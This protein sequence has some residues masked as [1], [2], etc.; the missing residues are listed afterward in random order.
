MRG[1]YLQ[2][3][4]DAS[5]NESRSNNQAAD[6]HLE[7]SV[8]PRVIVH[9]DPAGVADRFGEGTEEHGDEEC[10]HAVAEAQ[11]GLH[12]QADG[13]EGEEEGIGAQVRV[14]TIDGLVDGAGR[15]DLGTVRS[16]V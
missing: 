2:G 8:G 13:E 14:V 10:P 5:G 7:T 11:K 16:G 1:K 3:E 6:L 15:I 9:D 4:I 12:D